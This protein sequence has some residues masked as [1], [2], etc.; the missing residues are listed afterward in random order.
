[1]LWI[2]IAALIFSFTSYLLLTD[3]ELSLLNQTELMLILGQIIIGIALLIVIIDASSSI[4]TEFE[5]ETAE[6]L[7]LAP[8]SIKEFVLGKFLAS[9]TLWFMI[10]I[11]SIPYVIVASSGSNLTLAFLGYL[12]LLGTLG[13]TGTI[14]FIFSISLVYRSTKNTLTTSIILL[15]LLA[16]PALFSTALKTNAASA[17]FSQINPIDNMF[18][19]LDNVLVDYQTSPLQNWQFILPLVI[20]CV[21][22]GGFLILNMKK[23]NEQGCIRND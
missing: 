16:T 3:K 12:L 18:S 22:M 4:A 21:L 2:V 1:M 11:V 7:F 23:F 6:T 14:A 15:L 8:I 10:F 20:F 5:K 19:S 13:I 9:L 17:V